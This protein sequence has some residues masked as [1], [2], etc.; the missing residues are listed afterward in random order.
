MVDVPL[1]TLVKAILLAPDL[2]V[3]QFYGGEGKYPKPSDHLF[4]NPFPPKKKKGK[5][6]K[7]K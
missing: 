2:P 4:A 3:H 6:K 5:K 1:D 7:K